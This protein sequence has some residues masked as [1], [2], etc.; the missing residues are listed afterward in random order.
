MNFLSYKYIFDEWRQRNKN[1]HSQIFS[2]FIPLFTIIIAI[3]SVHTA[4]E[5]LKMILIIAIGS[6]IS[7]ITIAFCWHKFQ[8]SFIKKTLGIL[9]GE[10]LISFP[11]QPIEDGSSAPAGVPTTVED[12]FA[13]KEAA[14]TFSQLGIPYD[15]KLHKDITPSEKESKHIFIIGGPR[16]N[17][18]ASEFL[19][20]NQNETNPKED[21]LKNLRFVFKKHK[22]DNWKK[23]EKGELPYTIVERENTDT[24]VCFFNKEEIPEPNILSKEGKKDY[25][26]FARIKNPW[27]KQKNKEKQK[28]IFL[29]AGIYG[30][31]TWGATH[32]FLKN[33]VAFTGQS[34]QKLHSKTLPEEFSQTLPEEFSHVLE[35]TSN[36]SVDPP[37]VEI[38]K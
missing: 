13:L 21:K 1:F 12:S 34:I 5:Y 14:Q 31:G 10:V 35:I 9:D 4:E 29:I 23:D 37:K 33:L 18:I 19:K 6:L 16:A 26:I 20:I 11:T 38:Y 2:I 25:A 8:H 3:Y 15:V 28:Y 17:D 24:Q 30:L 36:G 32:F 22:D 7:A 27:Y